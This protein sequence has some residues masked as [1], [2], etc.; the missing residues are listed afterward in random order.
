LAAISSSLKV[1]F[2]PTLMLGDSITAVRRAYSAMRAFCSSLKPVVPMT[3]LTPSSAQMARWSMVPSGRVKSIRQSALDSAA[4]TSLS[5]AMPLGWP[6]KAEGSV[7]SAGLSGRSRAA[8]SARSSLCRMAS[9]SMR[10][11]RPEAPATATRRRWLLLE[12]VAVVAFM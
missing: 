7:P 8:V 11:M 4:R 5:M 6:R 3:S 12:E 2:T 10:P 1:T 9:I